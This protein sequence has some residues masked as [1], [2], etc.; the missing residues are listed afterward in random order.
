MRNALLTK[1]AHSRLL[2]FYKD[3]GGAIRSRKG[4]FILRAHSALFHLKELLTRM[5]SW[6]YGREGKRP[7]KGRK[8]G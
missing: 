5:D 7:K 2:D 3:F 4:L 6:G 1:K 8:H